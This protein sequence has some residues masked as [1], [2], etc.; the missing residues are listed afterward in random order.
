MTG[1]DV[2]AK[3]VIISAV[4]GMAKATGE[5]PAQPIIHYIHQVNGDYT[6][7]S[8]RR[9]AALFKPAEAQKFIRAAVAC[10]YKL[11]TEAVK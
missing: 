2:S 7:E 5:A 6:L 10:A 1:D 11:R 9:G 3:L 4:V 8:M